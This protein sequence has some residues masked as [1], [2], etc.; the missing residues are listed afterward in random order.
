MKEKG[1]FGA[2]R[3]FVEYVIG[4]AKGERISDGK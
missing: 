3:L 1:G 2:V 4:E